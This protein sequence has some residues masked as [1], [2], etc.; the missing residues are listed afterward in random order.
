MRPHNKNIQDSVCVC[1]CVRVCVCVCVRTRACMHIY[2]G[3][4]GGMKPQFVK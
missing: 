3:E 1:V 4:M 2:G